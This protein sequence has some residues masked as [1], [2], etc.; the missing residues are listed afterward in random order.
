MGR[1]LV[2]ER[3]VLVLV[4]QADAIP[5][6]GHVNGVPAL[7]AIGIGGGELRVSF[8]T[9]RPEGRPVVIRRPVFRV[10]EVVRNGPTARLPEE[11]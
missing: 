5:G 11:R 1:D 8:V 2:D 7:S 3:V 9:E 6:H 10:A 4:G